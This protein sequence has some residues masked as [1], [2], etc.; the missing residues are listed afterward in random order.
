MQLIPCKKNTTNTSIFRSTL[1]SLQT[2]SV[3]CTVCVSSPKLHDVTS[4]AEG[5]RLWFPQCLECS[6]S[7][8]TSRKIKLRQIPRTACTSP[9]CALC[10]HVLGG[11][12]FILEKLHPFCVKM[13]QK[14]L[15]EMAMGKF[16][17]S[18]PFLPP[19][20]P[21][22]PYIVAAIATEAMQKQGCG[23]ISFEKIDGK[24]GFLY[25]RGVLGKIIICVAAQGQ[26]VNDP[27]HSVAKYK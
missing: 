27:F 2:S 17:H 8:T 19:I 12:V 4:L 6:C 16:N 25:K 9:C 24:T 10:Q 7:S 5:M 26:G 13:K 23:F 3:R 18:F 14:H 22:W 1:P 15:L 11:G 21:L 20:L